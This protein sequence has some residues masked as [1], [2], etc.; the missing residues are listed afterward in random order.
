MDTQTILVS[1]ATG[2]LAGL[3]SFA[4]TLLVYRNRKRD[5]ER[6]ITNSKSE[7]TLKARQQYAS[8][9][10]EEIN[11]LVDTMAKYQSI[12]F[13]RGLGEHFH[14]SGNAFTPE[15]LSELF[16]LGNKIQLMLRKSSPFYPE[17]NGVVSEMTGTASKD[18]ANLD[19]E[20]YAELDERYINLCHNY[21]SS[22]W[23]NLYTSLS[24]EP[25]IANL[26]R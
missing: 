15:D 6:Q 25:H 19:F 7:L 23:G 10:K 3:I 21:I 2:T 12:A 5:V 13:A 24:S 1:I 16:Y 11:L 9:Y 4:S 17:L 20:Y 8:I 22:E 26:D 18:N 14:M